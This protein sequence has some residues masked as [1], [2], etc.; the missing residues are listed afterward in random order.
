MK[1][2]ASVFALIG[3]CYFSFAQDVHLKDYDGYV[4]GDGDWG[5]ALDVALSDAGPTG[6][7]LLDR[8]I[9]I[10]SWETTTTSV[11]LAAAPG[12]APIIETNGLVI[13]ATGDIELTGIEVQGATT[14]EEVPTLVVFRG[15]AR[16]KLENCVIRD[17]QEGLMGLNIHGTYEF[18]N[19]NFLNSGL[20]R[21]M[22][23]N[24]ILKKHKPSGTALGIASG[25]G[26]ELVNCHFTNIWGIGL[27]LNENDTQ[28][29]FVDNMH[30]ENIEY[31]GGIYMEGDHASVLNNTR[32]VTVTNSSFS[33]YSIN[34]IRVNGS[35]HVLTGNEFYGD[36]TAAI[37]SHYL[38]DSRISGNQ[39]FPENGGGI[40][41]VAYPAAG[42]GIEGVLVLGNTITKTGSGIILNTKGGT[43]RDVRVMSNRIN[44]SRDWAI[45]AWSASP[46]SNNQFIYNRLS[47]Q[48]GRPFGFSAMNIQSQQAPVISHNQILG[49]AGS[50]NYGHVTLTNCTAPKMTGNSLVAPD[51][52]NRTK[53]GFVFFGTTSIELESTNFQ[54][55]NVP[56]Y[57][58]DA[59][60]TISGVNGSTFKFGTCHW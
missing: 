32:N 9:F 47:N 38:R 21:R 16:V 51:C 22:R 11:R 50:G 18:R 45:V 3:F 57:K 58:L 13:H 54:E 48:G 43:Y 46:T 25:T 15:A 7:V 40:E 60:S 39:I 10:H 5:A 55:I 59:G 33:G 23:W 1:Y 26:G 35:N 24:P 36:G 8:T 41:L 28:R 30:V 14:A 29:L 56:G 6:T 44:D 37:K 19:T 53:G 27:W 49:E 52:I 20:A 12:T 4:A 2:V 42:H 31:G 17:A 34:G